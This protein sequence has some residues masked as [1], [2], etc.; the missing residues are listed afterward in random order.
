MLK[1]IFAKAVKGECKTLQVSL[2]HN[3][4]TWL[5]RQNFIYH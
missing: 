4:N 5:I 2:A 3:E 1:V